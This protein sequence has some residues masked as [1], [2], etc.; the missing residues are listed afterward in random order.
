MELED[1]GKISEELA[2]IRESI[3]VVQELVNK[4]D[5]E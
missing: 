5:E 1:C 3:K 4:Y 2:K